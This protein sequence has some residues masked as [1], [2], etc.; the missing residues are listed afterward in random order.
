MAAAFG[1][2]FQEGVHNGFGRLRAQNE[3]SLERMLISALILS[4]YYGYFISTL[5]Y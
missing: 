4:V 3:Y 1:F 2:G 5:L